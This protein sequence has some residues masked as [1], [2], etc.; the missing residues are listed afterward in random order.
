[1]TRLILLLFS[2]I[3]LGLCQI[4]SCAI[5]PILVHKIRTRPDLLVEITQTICK[6]LLDAPSDGELTTIC[7]DGL[8]GK[9]NGWMTEILS[10]KTYE[11]VCQAIEICPTV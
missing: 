8:A 11:E 5:C 9:F 7:V 4:D 2:L 6:K 1:M 3:A 10:E